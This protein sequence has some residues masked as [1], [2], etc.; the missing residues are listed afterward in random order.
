MLLDVT[1]QITCLPIE[2]VIQ[3]CMKYRPGVLAKE[4]DPV[5]AQA[6]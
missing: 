4:V 2:F 3:H 5:D 6:T 1:A